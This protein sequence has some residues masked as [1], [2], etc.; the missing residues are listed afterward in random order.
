MESLG[1]ILLIIGVLIVIVGALVYFGARSGLLERIP[2]GR[3]PGD[4]RI[5]GDGFTCLFPL[6]TMIILSV[7]GTIVLNLIIRLIN[8]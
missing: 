3:L 6:A 2:F 8:R 4:I 7:V 1:K 5:N